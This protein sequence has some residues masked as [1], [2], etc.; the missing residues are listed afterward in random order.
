MTDHLV[1]ADKLTSQQAVSLGQVAKTSRNMTWSTSMKKSD[2]TSS[3]NFKVL[4]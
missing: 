2:A 4:K 3:S 1:M